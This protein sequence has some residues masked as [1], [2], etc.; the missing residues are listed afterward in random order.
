[1]QLAAIALNLG[2]AAQAIALA[3]RAIPVVRQGQNASLLATLMMVKAQALELAGSTADA[4]AMRLDSMSWAR[5]GFGAE[6]VV[7]ARMSEI[8][9]LMPSRFKLAQTKG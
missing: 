9:A 6:S 3:D 2:D 1:M 7:R 8:S 4:K 5:Y